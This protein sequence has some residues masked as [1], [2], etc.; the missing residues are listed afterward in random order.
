MLLSDFDVRV[1]LRRMQSDNIELG[2]SQN[3]IDFFPFFLSFVSWVT[4]RNK[5]LEGINFAV[6]FIV[7]FV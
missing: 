4:M 2:N 3:I 5:H 6:T 1:A 7:S